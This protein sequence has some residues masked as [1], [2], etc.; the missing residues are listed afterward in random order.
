[1]KNILK[2]VF[3]FAGLCFITTCRRDTQTG[4]QYKT[5][6]VIVI[7]VDGARYSETWGDSTQQYIP[8][9]RGQLYN[10]G[11]VLN[12]FRNNGYTWT[13]AGHDAMCTGYYEPLDN[14]GNQLPQYP[15]MF[16]YYRKATGAPMEKTW[17]ITSKDKLFVLANCRDASMQSLYTPSYDCGVAG[18]FTGYRHD[19]ITYQKIISTFTQYHP[20]LMLVNF[21]EPDWSGHQ[22]VWAN[23]TAGIVSTDHYIALI[24][25]YLQN[26]PYYKGTTT[27]IVTN[28]HGRHLDNVYDGFVSHGD[29]C[30]GCRHIEFIAAGPD[31]RHGETL[32]YDY[33]QIDIPKTIAELMQF[34]MPTGNGKV[35]R[36]LFK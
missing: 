9:R 21:R 19:S 20:D 12:N 5:K 11:V 26:D 16:Q 36:E 14:G 17:V 33:E 7:V 24:W 18:P 27:L 22:G 35:M 3:L 25:N 28:D 4:P 29:G 2:I 1:M 10:E 6:H 34:D 32:N 30:E 15:S 13:S 8:F 31:F 23:Y